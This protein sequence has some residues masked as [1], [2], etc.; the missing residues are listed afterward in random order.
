MNEREA[1]AV[2]VAA[3]G[4]GYAKREAAL[5]EAGSALELLADPYAYRALLGETGVSALRRS[6]RG[7]E[8]M[9]DR[10]NEGGVHLVIRGEAGYPARLM[11]TAKPPHLL[12]CLGG[13]DLDD[14]LSL[15]VV[16]TRRASAY[17]LRHTRALAK[18]LAAAG[19]CIVSGLALGIDASAHEGALDAGGRTIA[20]L[21][22][23]LDKLY[24]QENRRLMERILDGGGSVISEYPPG[25]GPTRYSFLQ[26]N[27]IIAG[28]S[29]GVL[30]TE[31]ARRSGALSTAHHALDEGR[32]VFALPGDIDRVSAQLPNQLIAEGATP[33]LS[34]RD[35]LCRVV[36][37]RDAHPAP[38]RMR[39]KEQ[40]T[41]N[42]AAYAAEEQHAR[43]AKLAKEEPKL[44]RTERIICT[45]LES[46][47]LDF[48][49]LCEKTGE[50]P[51]DLSAVLM[52]ME[53][54]GLIE[55]LPGLLYRRV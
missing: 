4:I 16:G 54:D 31:G 43:P 11:Q 24:P 15:A 8:R 17:G 23:A 42:T 28:M 26:R 47:T 29:I 9:L 49:Q 13:A 55:S 51:D 41:E 7:A 32:E 12:F 35:I 18:E 1:M 19:M 21:G 45:L 52:M 22:S 48:D 14:P 25:M 53:L 36:I 6:L 2:L 3:Q 10:L 50:L 34:A 30:V 38:G 39:A 5:K 37:E 20:V 33:V 27:R 44:G 46:E 40:R